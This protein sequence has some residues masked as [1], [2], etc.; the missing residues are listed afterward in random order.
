MFSGH[1]RFADKLL[2]APQQLKRP[3]RESTEPKPQSSIESRKGERQIAF[4]GWF[5]V[6]QPG[7][8]KRESR[9]SQDLVPYI[10]V[11]HLQR[12]FDPSR[13]IRGNVLFCVSSCTA[14]SIE[15]LGIEL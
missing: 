6:I 3:A 9:Q 13:I 7:L 1:C 4:Q 2:L 11:S 10:E 15:C 12:A 8:E 5:A 14:Y